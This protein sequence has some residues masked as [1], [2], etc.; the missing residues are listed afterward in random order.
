ME[1]GKVAVRSRGRGDLGA[2]PFEE[3]AA[4]LKEEVDN[5]TR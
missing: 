1:E 5:K 3:F 4:M 2:M